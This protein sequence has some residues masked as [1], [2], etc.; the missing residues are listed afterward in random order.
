MLPPVRRI[1]TRAG[2]LSDR[3]ET[4]HREAALAAAVKD[5]LADV[6]REAHVCASAVVLD[7]ASKVKDACALLEAERQETACRVAAMEATATEEE[8]A[9]SEAAAQAIAQIVPL[10]DLPQAL[11]QL[12]QLADGARALTRCP[13]E[14]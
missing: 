2:A 10:V 4:V 8:A 3:E 12:R 5:R 7:T 11:G 14:V 6:E 13:K 9:R 1:W